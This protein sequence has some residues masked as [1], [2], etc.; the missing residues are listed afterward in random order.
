MDCTTELLKSVE[1]AEAGGFFE[2]VGKMSS[3]CYNKVM[4]L[5]T[6]ILI[7][8]IILF[9]AGFLLRGT[10]QRKTG[11]AV[12]ST[13]LMTVGALLLLYYVA[14]VIGTSFTGWQEYSEKF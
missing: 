8:G 10:G 4:D 12:I 9:V 6:I 13:V 11:V 7:A 3:V 14:Q 2:V 5:N 1:T